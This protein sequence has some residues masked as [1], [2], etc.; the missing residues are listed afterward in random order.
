MHEDKAIGC[1]IGAAFGDSLG[2]AVEFM[3]LPAI[4]TRYGI[5]GIQRCRP[6]YGHP[7][8]SITDDTQMALATAAG[9]TCAMEHNMAADVSI[10]RYQLWCSYQRWLVSQ[11]RPENCRAPGSTCLSALRGKI[12]GSQSR[13]L[14]HSAGCGA[15]MRVHPVGIAYSQYPTQAFSIG[16]ESGVLTHGH[17][18]GYVPA[19]AF[20]TVIA[21]LMQG[22]DF[23]EAVMAMRQELCRL[24]VNRSAGTIEAVDLGMQTLL[25]DDPAETIDQTIRCHGSS[26]GGWQGHDALAITLYAVRHAPADPIRAVQIAVNHSGDSDSTGSLAGAI[27]GAWYG[28]RPFSDHLLA[29]KVQLEHADELVDYGKALAVIAETITP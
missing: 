9:I 4:R 27:M 10:I 18:N 16:M 7:A 23:F 26:G 15:I 22:K 13:P 6:V 11:N 2:A 19:G 24:P 8:G 25:S 12:A 1:M 21:W 3:Q 29:T 5:R 14:N 20:A 28:V 17:V